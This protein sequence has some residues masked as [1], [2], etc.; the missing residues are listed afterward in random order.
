MVFSQYTFRCVT[1]VQTYISLEQFLSMETTSPGLEKQVYS[2]GK[3]RRMW[4]LRELEKFAG[5]DFEN[6]SGHL[7]LVQEYEGVAFE[8]FLE[9]LS[10]FCFFLSFSQIHFMY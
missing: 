5:K 2:S 6:L 1:S 3:E 9:I 10:L 4:D 7:S 8:F